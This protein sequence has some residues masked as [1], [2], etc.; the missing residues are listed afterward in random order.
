LCLP[1]ASADALI[2]NFIDEGGVMNSSAESVFEI[3]ASYWESILT[4]DVTV[5]IGVE[6][7]SLEGRLL[8][9]SYTTQMVYSV[10]DWVAGVNDTRSDSTLDQTL[11]L[12]TLS[13]EGGASFIATG[14]NAAGGN[15][16]TV[17]DYIEGDTVSSTALNL[18]TA[19]VKAIGGA[20]DY[21]SG[22]VDE[23]DASI[24]FN[25][26]AHFDYDASDGITEG[27]IDLLAVAIHEI[28]HALGFSSGVDTMDA[29]AE[30]GGG[31]DGYD[32]NDT[33]IYSAL[34]LFRYSD[35]PTDVVA[36]D[37]AIL[38]VSVGTASYFSIDGG[39]TAL[40]DNGFSTGTL[41]GDGRQASH[42]KD[43]YDCDELGL[44]NPTQCVGTQGVVT[45]LDIAAMDAIG[46]NT[47]IDALAEADYAVSTR[48]IYRS[49]ATAV[50]EPQ[51]WAMLLAGFSMVGGALR[52]RR[53][54]V[55][56]SSRQTRAD[57][58]VVG[59]IV[60]AGVGSVA[61]RSAL[62]PQPPR[63]R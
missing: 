57:F 30:P 55:V 33:E 43:S 62:A 19:T 7:T 10:A 31:S 32:Y 3:A 49:F 41:N 17:L 27:S 20:A 38:D 56:A 42:W 2:I 51:I 13:D 11:V 34:D 47:S 9:A 50:P 53:G 59:S 48:E 60:S 12:P 6:L 28:G 4:N 16:A 14:T 36:G 61:G 40:Y 37:G 39:E 44:M 24:V 22:N 21:S 58:S 18:N 25:A 45:A 15:D 26:N 54:G 46:W 29:A 52:R 1:A 5:T 63:A 35:D 23:I 8:G